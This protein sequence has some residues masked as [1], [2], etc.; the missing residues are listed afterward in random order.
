MNELK[1]ALAKFWGSF[2]NVPG[3]EPKF[4][5]AFEGGR[6]T[7]PEKQPFPYITYPVIKTGFGGQTI[8]TVSVWD[9]DMANPG[10]QGRV[11][12]VLGQISERISEEGAVIR[13][14]NN[15]GMA[16]LNRSGQNFISYMADP[17]DKFIVRGVVR[18]QLKT[19]S[20]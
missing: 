10:F 18:L 3:Q 15:G 11:D 8:L 12:H 20:Y 6:I 19:F 17:D 9:K 16:W 1:I 2:E 4:V 5:P 13:L 7:E 14:G